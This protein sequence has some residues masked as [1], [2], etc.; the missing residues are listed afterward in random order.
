LNILKRKKEMFLIALTMIIVVSTWMYVVSLYEENLEMNEYKILDHEFDDSV[1]NLELSLNQTTTFIYGLRGFVYSQLAE[2]IDE[3]SF[4][5]YADKTQESAYSIQNFSIAPDNIQKFVYPL[6][7]NEI[8]I[9]HDLNKDERPNVQADLKK[10]INTKT[11]VIGGPYELRQG[12]LGLIV[13]D[14]IFSEDGYW[15]IANI[16]VDVDDVIARSNM[17]KEYSNLSFTLTTSNGSQFYGDV[18]NKEPDF[19]NEIEVIN[20]KWTIDAYTD[21]EISNAD[22][23]KKRVEYFK[24]ISFFILLL[25]ITLIV[26]NIY[27][28]IILSDKV[29]DM[30]Y[31]DALTGLAN[32]RSLKEKMNEAIKSNHKFAVIFLD[33]DNFKN[34]NDVLGHSVGDKVLITISKRLKSFENENVSIFRWGGDEFL[35][36]MEDYGLE[37]YILPKFIDVI[38]EIREPIRLFDKDYKLSASAGISF[39]P[40][41]GTVV[42]ELLKN[43]DIAMYHAKK[44]GKN[45]VRFYNE[46]IGKDTADRIELE[47]KLNYALEENELEVYYQPKIDMST[48]KIIGAEALVRWFSDGVMIS[49]DKFIAIAESNGIIVEIDQ[50]VLRETIKFIS[51]WN[52]KGVKLSVSCNV[53][54]EQFN[55]QILAIITECFENHNIESGQLEV[56]ITETTAI[57]NFEYAKELI[58]KLKEVGVGVALDDF[59]TGYSSLSY[60]SKLRISTLK[61]DR[62]F[63]MKLEDN[64]YENKIVKAIISLASDINMKIIAEGVETKEQMN[65]LQ[66]LGCHICQGFYYSKALPLEKFNEYYGIYSDE[67]S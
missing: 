58:N 35:I 39:Y 32:R 30:I 53:S 59:G 14:P 42:E 62:S 26:S 3:V 64:G 57:E 7:G 18:Y 21:G 34:I 43:S 47:H 22:G 33:L 23:Y 49:P 5:Q 41:D 56:E 19:S 46:D 40:D 12:G 11:T 25:T 60:L 51:D 9:G 15:G 16:V 2:G 24:V 29:K 1:S 13:R 28:N 20:E 38:E 17:I 67:N 48:N 55:E 6:K 31:K 45:K 37:E 52:D 50:F 54:A 8:T 36:I 63:I 27:R 4:N 10:I 61:I 44:T 65:I 66:S